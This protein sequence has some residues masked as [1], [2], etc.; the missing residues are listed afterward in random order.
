MVM[1]LIMVLRGQYPDGDD[2]KLRL[3]DLSKQV[4]LAENLGY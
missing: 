3:E 1:D 4:K 2:M